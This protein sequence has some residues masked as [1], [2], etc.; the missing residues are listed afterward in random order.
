MKVGAC[1]TPSGR[2]LAA[3]LVGY[4]RLMG[5]DETATL[6]AL[7][8]HRKEVV[9]AKIAEHKGRIVKL[10][11]DGMLA[12]FSSVVPWHSS[13]SFCRLH[14]WARSSRSN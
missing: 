10:T 5:V 8:A 13:F 11:G 4:S 6:M 1:G 7:N 2:Y 9:E 12:E 14:N 3:D